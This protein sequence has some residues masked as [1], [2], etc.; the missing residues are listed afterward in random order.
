M[1]DRVARRRVG[2]VDELRDVTR[3]VAANT[4]TAPTESL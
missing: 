4:F 2:D 3:E 1:N